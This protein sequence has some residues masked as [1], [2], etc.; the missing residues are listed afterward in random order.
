MNGLLFIHN[1]YV[2][3][4]GATSPWNGTFRAIIQSSPRNLDLENTLISPRRVVFLIVN[5]IFYGWKSLIYSRGV[6]YAKFA[7]TV[8]GCTIV[9]GQSTI[10]SKQT[11]Q[12]II[13][14]VICYSCYVLVLATC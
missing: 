3:E 13:M 4:G 10:F 6:F 7:H 9:H 14:F 5:Q 2:K 11:L 12:Y 1:H 8:C